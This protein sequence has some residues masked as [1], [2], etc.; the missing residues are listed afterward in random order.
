MMQHASNESSD[1]QQRIAREEALLAGATRPK[2]HVERRPGPKL[3]NGAQEG[4]WFYDRLFPG[5][6]QY[7]IPS[8]FRIRGRLDVEILQRSFNYVVARHEA[9]RTRISTIDGKPMQVCRDQAELVIPLSDLSALDGPQKELKA[10]ELIQEEVTSG[11]NLAK[12]LLVRAKLLKLEEAEHILIVVLHHIICDFWSLAIFDEELSAAY[13]AFSKGAEPDLAPLELH[14]ADFCQLERT[15]S[16]QEAIAHELDY[17]K[18]K[19]DD[20]A[21]VDYLPPDFPR[22]PRQSLS[23]SRL[24]FQI[25]ASLRAQLDS[26]CQQQSTTLYTVLLAAFKALLFRYSS[27]EDIT[28]GVPIQ[29]RDFPG[30]DRAIGFFVNVLPL[31]TRISGQ[32]TFSALVQ[33]ISQQSIELYSHKQIPFS[34][35]VERLGSSR[36]PSRHPIFQ[37][38]FQCFSNPLPGPS[39]TAEGTERLPIDNHTSKFDLTLSITQQPAG[40][41]GEIEFCDALFTRSS[42]ERMAVHFVDFLRALAV[43]PTQPIAKARLLTPD[44]EGALLVEYNQTTTRYPRDRTI[45]ELFEEQCLASPRKIALRFGHSELSYEQLDRWAN[46]LASDLLKAGVAP[47]QRVGLSME[48]CSEMIAGLLAILKI[49]G[50]YVPLDPSYPVE[51]LRLLVDEAEL[52]VILCS[53]DAEPKLPTG[54]RRLVITEMA[55]LAAGLSCSK[56]N[57]ACLPE[58][59]AYIMYT[60]GS[61]GE[62]K[63]VIIPHRG[64]VRLVKET[65]YLT[66]TTEDVFLQLAPLAFDAS[67]LE[68]WGP[69]LN[70]G[71]LVIYPPHF[72]SIQQLGSVLREDKINTLW[73]TAALFHEIVDHHVDILR[74]VHRV[75]AGGEA[76]SSRHVAK[77]VQTYPEST[78]INGYGPTENTTFTCCYTFPKNWTANRPVP[79]GR[80]IANSYVH[81]LDPN[82]NLMPIGLPGELHAGGDGLALGYLN[83]PELTAEKFI[84]NPLNP[85]L[86]KLYRTGDIARYLP[87]GNIEFLGRRDNQIKIRGFRV[88][89]EE[90]QHALQNITTVRAAAVEVEETSPG[91]KT[92]V[93]YVVPAGE[94]ISAEAIREELLEKV[95][96]FL[97]PARIVLLEKLPLKPNGKIDRKELA[98]CKRKEAPAPASAAPLNPIEE[99]LVRIWEEVLGLKGIRRDQSFLD[100]GGHSL[101]AIRIILR[102]NQEFQRNLRPS[103][104]FEAQTIAQLAR[105]IEM[106]QTET[107]PMIKPRAAQF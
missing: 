38:V 69:L 79:I 98:H 62:P 52:Q 64:V 103:V 47:G 82:G 42:I 1:L 21:P 90:I 49:G 13:A 107:A 23:G 80:P 19:L 46:Q 22:P 84:S 28:I 40:L 57:V 17:W 10:A 87:D 97:A 5:S 106:A 41:C 15:R 63:G 65:N 45:H 60:S 70:G 86:G 30:S 51:R 78:L 92:V 14:F 93:A 16:T 39:F 95:P 58:A 76:L 61:T 2:Q 88:E 35:L 100:A 8:A 20:C 83:R 77:F 4:L 9:L 89:L 94:A 29:M 34:E 7:T 12:D 53:R 11:F 26:I 33:E 48:R 91:D 31:R 24:A 67:T 25:P 66:F 44:E 3:L 101:L 81:I 102:V 43:D 85:G 37:T 55:H 32:M 75:L 72:E 27:A 36:D 71:T 50:C 104:L 68:I 99:R 59:P 6:A 73:L 105:R 18:Q 54:C 96:A 74:G 56:P